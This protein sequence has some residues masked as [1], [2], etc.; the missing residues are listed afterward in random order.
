[1]ASRHPPPQGG[2]G[3]LRKNIYIFGTLHSFLDWKQFEISG[4]LRR[5]LTKI[6][7]FAWENSTKISRN[8]SARLSCDREANQLMIFSGGRKP[9]MVQL[10]DP[11]SWINQNHSLGGGDSAPNWTDGELWKM[12]VP[13][14]RFQDQIDGMRDLWMWIHERIC[15]YPTMQS[16]HEFSESATMTMFWMIRMRSRTILTKGETLSVELF[17]SIDKHC[18]CYSLGIDLI[19]IQPCAGAKFCAESFYGIF[20]KIITFTE[21]HPNTPRPQGGLPSCARMTIPKNFRKCSPMVQQS[22]RSI[23]LWI[24]VEHQVKQSGPL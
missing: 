21:W 1:M 18:D 19:I 6:I 4:R 15:N 16:K 23:Y 11:I 7:V 13:V 17:G 5:P 10:M 24:V 8:P 2:G 3:T 12:K 22:E 20:S 9:V 14:K